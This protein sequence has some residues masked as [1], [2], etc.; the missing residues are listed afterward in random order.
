MKNE[1]G[2]IVKIDRNIT[3]TTIKGCRTTQ[4]TYIE[5]Y[6]QDWSCNEI[7]NSVEISFG[8]YY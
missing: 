8:E 1:G 4:W 5:A 7:T 3:K 2:L 6:K